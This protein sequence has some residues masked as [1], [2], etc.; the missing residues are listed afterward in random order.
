M[1][2]LA[3]T[4]LGTVVDVL[5]NIEKPQKRIGFDFYNHFPS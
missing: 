5:V 4:V 3:L 2:A 1:L